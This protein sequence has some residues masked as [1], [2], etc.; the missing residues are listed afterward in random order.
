MSAT[1]EHG[2]D[3]SLTGAPSQDE[4]GSASRPPRSHTVRQVA[5]GAVVLVFMVAGVA[6]PL[7]LLSGSFQPTG[8]PSQTAAGPGSAAPAS[9]LAPNTAVVA[10]TDQGTE[11]I[12]PVVRP[13]PDGVHFRTVNETD[14]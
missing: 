4:N 5:L 2:S 13:Q 11:V 8:G 9:P 6:V 3:P 7:A 12:T 10:C 14:R 1:D